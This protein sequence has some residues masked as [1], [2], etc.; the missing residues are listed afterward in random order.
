MN[1]LLPFLLSYLVSTHKPTLQQYHLLKSFSLLLLGMFL[2][3]LATLNFSLSL[4][5]GV[6]SIP[7]SFAQPWPGN[8]A[9]RYASAALLQL[10]SPAAVVYSVAAYF[11]L[12]VGFVLKEAAFGWDVWGMYTSVVVWCLWWP[13]WLIG[14]LLVLGQPVS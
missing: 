8:D 4:L 1:T 3:A 12:D 11:G 2:S 10:V 5:V 7:L 6:L 9:A 14:S 13:A